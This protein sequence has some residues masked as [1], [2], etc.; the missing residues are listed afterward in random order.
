MSRL[1]T[2]PTR[3]LLALLGLAVVAAVAMAAVAVSAR[4]SSGS[5]PPAEPLAQAVHDALAAPAP[6]GATARV[7]FTNNLFP[8]GG[9][10]G[11]AGSPLMSGATGRMWVTND[12]YGRVELQS[13][14]GDAQ[15]V[16][17]PTKLTV[18]DASSNTVYTMALPSRSDTASSTTPDRKQPPSVDQISAF[19][20]KL[21][22]HVALSGAVP[23]IV[24][25]EGAYTVTGS[26]KQ[27][28]GLVGAAD[29]A[30]DAQNGVP[31]RVAITPKGST[32]PALEL[33]ATDVSFGPVSQSDVE[34]SPPGDA[35][36]VDLGSP[37]SSQTPGETKTAPVTGLANVQAAVPFTLVAPDT[38]AGRARGTV[39]LVGKGDSAGAVLVYGQGLDSIVVVERKADSQ[40]STGGPLGALPKV[41]IAGATGHELAT[42]LGT[43]VTFDR[44]GVTYVVVGSVEP[45]V[46][47][48]AAAALG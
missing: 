32:T 2:L 17:T 5:E 27:N 9:L 16:W 29:L 34:I 15:I 28:G 35:K 26:P 1:R 30:W 7:T 43:A 21:G 39:A 3:K 19:L 45:S 41:S 13:D 4:G 47:E 8:S 38:L 46:A 40:A 36:V 25:G 33:K 12:G 24:A 10:L 6:D 14:A 42:Q 18:Y 20:T 44:D 31:L 23:S 22:E 48:A 11:Q 37:G